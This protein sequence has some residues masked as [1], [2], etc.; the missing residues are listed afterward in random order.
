MNREMMQRENQRYEEESA[1]LDLL[2]GR[3]LL[4]S[5]PLRGQEIGVIKLSW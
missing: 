2:C 1:Q 4:H 3:V 5:I